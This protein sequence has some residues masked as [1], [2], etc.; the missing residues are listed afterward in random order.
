MERSKIVIA[1]A[2][3]ASSGKY[4]VKPDGARAMNQLFELVATLINELEAEEKAAAE[5]AEGENSD[6]IAS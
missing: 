2:N 6:D 3:L 4:E 1:L 5:A